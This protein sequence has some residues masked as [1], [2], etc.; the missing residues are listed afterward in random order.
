MRHFWVVL[1]VS[2]GLGMLAV[3]P[4]QATSCVLSGPYVLSSALSFE[5]TPGQFSGTFTFTPP[6]DCATPDVAGAVDLSLSVLFAGSTT[7]LT[8]VGSFPYTV[9]DTGMVTIGPG[10]FTGFA[11]A[12]EGTG[13]ISPPVVANAIVFVAAPNFPDPTVRLA[14]TAVRR[15]LDG[16][17][18]VASKVAVGI[19]AL[20]ANTVPNGSVAVGFNA[21]SSNTTSGLFNTAVGN[22]ALELSTTGQANTAV[23]SRALQN[24]TGDSNIALGVNAGLF[25]TTGNSNI[26]IGNIGV[27]GESN[28]IRI[29]SLSKTRTFITAIRGKTT[30]VADAVPVLIDSLNQLGT[31]SS[32]RRVKEDIQ[33]MGERSRGLLQLRP[34]TF[35]YRQPSVDGTKRLQYGL[36]AEEV[37]E[38]YPELVAF[39]PTGEAETILYQLLPAMLLNE[40]Q[41]QYRVNEAQETE[42]ERQ[43]RVNQAQQAELESLAARLAELA[44]RLQQL[45]RAAS[46]V[47]AAAVTP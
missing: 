44:G 12:A 26:M 28:T 3:G 10:L 27:A 11:A 14:G 40:L 42:L 16:L 23:G 33:D 8:F 30:D 4:A 20:A 13:P 24:N 41:H 43:H 46:V 1:I 34:V 5:G 6:A 19:G 32:S 15:T 9:D 7:P 35:R 39:T 25:L 29:G 31:T 37:A 2:T 47:T 38:L 18:V 45:E 17:T 22:Q 36:I 21:L